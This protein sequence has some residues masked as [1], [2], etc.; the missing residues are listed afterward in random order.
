MKRLAAAALAA[1]AFSSGAA[2]FV[3]ASDSVV[4]E[5]LAVRRDDPFSR[6]AVGLREQLRQEPRNA[7]VAVRLAGLHVERARADGDPRHWGRAQAVLSPWWKEKD[8]PPAVLLARAQIRQSQHEFPAAIEDLGTLLR[9]EPANAQAWLT[10]ATVQLVTGDAA[11]SG[12]SCERLA[13]LTL[14]LV[15]SACRASVAGARGDAAGG[16]RQ[17]ATALAASRPVPAGIQA[18]ALGLAAELAER[19]GDASGAEAA[20]RRALSLDPGDAYNMAA[21]ADFLIDAG[22]PREALAIITGDRLSEGLQL[23]RVIALRATGAPAAQDE[24]RR[25]RER[26]AAARARGDRVHL[27][28]EARF[29]LEVERDAPRA[30]ALALENWQVQKEPADAR[31]ALEAAAAAGERNGAAEVA[32]WARQSRLEGRAVRDALGKLG[33]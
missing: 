30:L 6:E 2:P 26:F 21:F 31:V 4:L 15:A 28:E 20:Y 24:T 1:A 5:R 10:L 7:A 13:P 19:A 32:R 18:W 23:R 3:P 27:R 17:L 25:L 8:P 12:A 9:H 11:A 33:A 22:R 14:P 29:V 16:Q